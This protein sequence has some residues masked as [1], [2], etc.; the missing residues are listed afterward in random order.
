M[1]TRFKPKAGRFGV[2]P[3]FLVGKQ[4]DAGITA[5][6]TTFIPIA[7]PYRKLYIVRFTVHCET[8]PAGGAAIT[9][10]LLHRPGAVALTAA[11]DITA[12]FITNVN[13]SFNIPLLVAATDTQRILVEGDTL[14]ASVIAAGTVTTQPVGL[15][16]VV[17]ALVLE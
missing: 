6:A 4:L 5:S 2:A 3:V 15:S 9:A 1:D 10:T 8:R 7:S 16:F 12:A 13:N 17:E 14:A 11:Q